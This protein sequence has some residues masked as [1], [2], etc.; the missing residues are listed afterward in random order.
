MNITVIGETNIDIRAIPGRSVSSGGCT[1]A[2]IGFHYGGVGR[3]IA[4]NLCLLGE[5]VRLMTVFGGDDFASRLM[6]DCK[7]IGIDLS[8]STQYEHKKS[9][10]FFSI[11]DE[12][13]NM[14]SAMSDIELNHRMDLSWIEGKMAEINRSDMVV[15]NTLL[16]AEALAYL[17]DNCSVPLYLDAVSPANALRLVEALE[18]SKKRAIH[19]LKCNLAEAR[20][21]TGYNNPVEAVKAMNSKGIEEVFLT[22]GEKGVVYGA[23]S[24]ALHFSSLPAQV[25]NVIGSGDAF[26]AGIVFAHAHGFNGK[27]ALPFGLAAA[28]TSIECEEACNLEIKTLHSFPNKG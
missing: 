9:P 6:E 4:Y 19:A 13:G 22:L 14:Q 12:K 28:K 8:L 20:A 1:P 15:A 18:N 23:R 7:S 27:E 11:N 10:L 16:N 26:L 21:I 25:I 24:I 5:Q 3:N 2:H 17:I